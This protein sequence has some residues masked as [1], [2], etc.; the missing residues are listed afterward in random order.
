MTTPGP[1]LWPELQKS[2]VAPVPRLVL[3]PAH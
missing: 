2:R 3:F 1:I